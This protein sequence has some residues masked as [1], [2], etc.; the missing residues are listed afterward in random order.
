MIVHRNTTA[1][2]HITRIFPYNLF[3]PLPYRNCDTIIHLLKG[4]IGTGILAMP[5]AIKNSGLLVGT[6][7]LVIL[8]V[9]CVSCMHML[10]NCAHTL[11]V[12]TR[13]PYMTYADVAEYSFSTSGPNARKLSKIARYVDSW[14]QLECRVWLCF[15]QRFIL[16][17]IYL[18]LFSGWQSI[19][20]YV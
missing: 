9:L 10:V 2:V 20:S 1:I 6:L 3:W 15:I 17:L 4:N 12:R 19:Y 7:G 14:A 5:D 8:S 16:L 11:G 18:Y 13:K